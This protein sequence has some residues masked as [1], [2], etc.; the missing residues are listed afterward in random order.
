[1]PCGY[2]AVP[3][4]A[5][6]STHS[7]V[8][9]VL[10]QCGEVLSPQTAQTTNESLRCN[11]DIRVFKKRFI[12]ACCRGV[13]STVLHSV[14]TD[15]HLPEVGQDHYKR[16]TMARSFCAYKTVVVTLRQVTAQQINGQRQKCTLRKSYQLRNCGRSGTSPV[17]RLLDKTG[18]FF[19]RARLA[20]A[21]VH[22]DS[23]DVSCVNAGGRDPTSLFPV[24]PL[25]K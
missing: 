22:S 16:V 14:H 1:M 5:A 9:F 17:K 20:T 7:V 19:F 15:E 24:K 3:S 10:R 23:S 11:H 6:N 21:N 4:E 25:Q 13:K 2:V 8:A 12:S 18:D